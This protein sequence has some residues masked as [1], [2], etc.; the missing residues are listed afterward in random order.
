MRITLNEVVYVAPKPKMKHFRTALEITQDRDL[1][2][3]N[4][5]MLDEVVLFVVSVF[6]DQFTVNDVYEDFDG[7]FI[8]L[9][10]EV[11]AF[12]AKKFGG[13]SKKK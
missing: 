3:L 11:I 6:G 9:L 12:V 10:E 5:E 7:D 2:H 8:E 1:N 13:E 4:T